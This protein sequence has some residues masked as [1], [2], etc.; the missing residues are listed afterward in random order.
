MKKHILLF[1]IFLIFT[2]ILRLFFF[3]IYTVNQNSMRSTYQSGDRVL[4]LKNF[5]KIDRN[6]IVVFNI[7]SENLIK[8][9]I[10]LP[11]D[12]LLVRNNKLYI[13]SKS[14][15]TPITANVTTS[16]SDEIFDKA[17]IYS[18]YGKDWTLSNFGPYLIPKEG[19]QI[20][21]TP[22]NTSTYDKLNKL[23]I[24]NYYTF[25]KDSYFVMGD[26]RLESVDSRF[27]G[28]IQ[29]LDI[30]GKVILDLKK[31]W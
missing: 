2:A 17:E 13:N 8:R 14:I 10:G 24:D 28:P 22:E 18:T 6:D 15:Q 19:T 29:K 4:I 7:D 11:G 5:Y 20:E 21:K 12:T 3:E 1:V 27:F 25:T 16:K 31:F 23:T 9:V 30:K 26:N